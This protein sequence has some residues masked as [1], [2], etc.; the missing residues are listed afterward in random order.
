MSKL[1]CL[2]EENNITNYIGIKHFNP[3]EIVILKSPDILAHY[4]YSSFESFLTDKGFKVFFK[5]TN[6]YNMGELQKAFSDTGEGDIVLLPNSNYAYIYNFYELVRSTPATLAFVEDDGEIYISGEHGFKYV[7]SNDVDLLV[8]DFIGSLGGRINHFSNILFEEPLC[9]E[10]LKIILKN[11][12]LYSEVFKYKTPMKSIL[13]DKGKVLISLSNLTAKEKN[14]IAYLLDLLN[15][16]HICS[17]RESTLSYTIYFQDL[18]YKEYLTKSGT[19]LEHLTFNALN[20]ISGIDDVKASVSFQWDAK[21]DILRNEIDVMGV[22]KNNLI[23]ISCKD[24]SSHSIEF[25]NE[26]FIYANNLGSEESIKILVATHEPKSIIQVRA[27]ELNIHIL[28]FRG[29]VSSFQQELR[30]IVSDLSGTMYL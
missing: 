17:K 22:F 8:N 20:S 6:P 16:N 7:H 27:K 18:R 14:F 19:W 5:N 2:F 10:L 1:Y 4:D 9:Q 11:P 26:L 3:M 30:R 28:I 15:K 23:C 25:L 12:N 24:T 13:D 29:D 21:N